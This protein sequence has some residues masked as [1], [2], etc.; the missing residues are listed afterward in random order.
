MIRQV[1]MRWDLQFRKTI[2]E[3]LQ[4]DLGEG[5]AAGV[6]EKLLPWPNDPGLEESG[7]EEEERQ[8]MRATADV[9]WTDLGHG[10]WGWG[11][12]WTTI[13]PLLG[14][15]RGHNHMWG[16]WQTRGPRR[17]RLSRSVTKITSL[18]GPSELESQ[19]AYWGGNI[20]LE[21]KKEAGEESLGALSSQAEQ[22]TIASVRSLQEQTEIGGRVPWA[23][24][25]L[26]WL[27]EMMTR[28]GRKSQ[29]SGS[30]GRGILRRAE[31]RG[32]GYSFQDLRQEH[33]Q[34]MRGR[35]AIGVG[36]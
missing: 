17:K 34:Q 22:E 19:V 29:D 20:H 30:Q 26:H 1:V 27:R 32:P 13:G 4:D 6:I 21:L 15:V 23:E 3:Q 16:Y 12:P 35:E 25:E 28:A 33:V 31:R 5:R 2:L 14:W 9:E 36:I 24:M 11:I 8:A 7:W 18:M 10:W